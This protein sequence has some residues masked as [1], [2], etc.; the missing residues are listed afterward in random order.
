MSRTIS[1][2]AEV[3]KAVT[4]LRQQLDHPVGHV[5]PQPCRYAARRGGG[6]NPRRSGTVWV[7]P[8]PESST[9]PVVRPEE[10]RERTAWIPTYMAGLVEG[11]EHDLRH[12]LAVRLR[13][14]RGLCEEDRVVLRGNTQLG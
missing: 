6:S 10:Y 8:S 11:L 4:A 1:R 9:I 3:T 5:A 12:L 14:H 7:T 13:V 2:S